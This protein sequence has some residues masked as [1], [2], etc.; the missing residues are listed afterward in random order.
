LK[1]RG[2]DEELLRAWNAMLLDIPKRRLDMLVKLRLHYRTFLLSNTNETHVEVIERELYHRHGV[3][4]FSDY[5]ERIYYSCR[6][7]MRKPD[8]EIFRHILKK[9]KLKP[10]ETIFIDDSIQHVKGA[11]ACGIR[12]YLLPRDMEVEDLLKELRIL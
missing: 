2:P 7:G 5:F 10:E 11:G 8:A 1:Y 6:H 12:A 4:N 9:E 3:K